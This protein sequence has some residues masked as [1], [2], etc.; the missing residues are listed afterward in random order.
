[1][2]KKTRVLARKS[3]LTYKAQAESICIME[4]LKFDTPKTK[5]YLNIL[6]K[7]DFAGKKTLFVTAENEKNVVLS[8]RNLKGAIVITAN[9]LNTYDILNANNVIISAGA[10]E[11]IDNLFS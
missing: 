11:K 9:Q 3:A 7:M 2:N 5:D 1:L 10:V 6:S 8:S 4:D